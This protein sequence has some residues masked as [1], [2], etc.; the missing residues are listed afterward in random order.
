MTTPPV[1]LGGLTG[2]RKGTEDSWLLMV[3]MCLDLW[4]SHLLLQNGCHRSSGPQQVPANCTVHEP[5][6]HFRVFLLCVR[7]CAPVA[8]SDLYHML[9]VIITLIHL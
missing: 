7:T 8:L 5:E 4:Q 9:E 6:N 1:D 2:D 3:Q